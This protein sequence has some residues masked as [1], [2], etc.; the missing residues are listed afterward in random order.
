MFTPAPR[1]DIRSSHHGSFVD[2][3]LNLHERV[4]G[5]YLGWEA[6]FH[7]PVWELSSRAETIM[8]SPKMPSHIYGNEARLPGKSPGVQQVIKEES[9]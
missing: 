5:K 4:V 8:Q 1:C 6:E 3:T 7:G 2:P 9:E